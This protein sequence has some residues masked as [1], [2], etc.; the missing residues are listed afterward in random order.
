MSFL[1][2]SLAIGVPSFALGAWMLACPL[3]AGRGMTAFGG[4]RKAAYVL[5]PIGWF[6]T[7]HALDI[8]GIEF[9]DKFLKVFPGELWLLA[10]V[11]IPLTL[12]WMP[13]LLAMRGLSAIL[14]LYPAVFFQCARQ[15]ESGGRLVAVAWTYVLLSLGM[16]AMFYPWRVQKAIEWLA[17]ASWR[18]RAAGALFAGAGAAVAVAAFLV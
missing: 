6:W 2:W 16:Y 18:M 15:V 12:A 17:A 13:K 8:I 4:C 7:A 9:F 10:A 1:G 11:L 5:V 3:A 14:M